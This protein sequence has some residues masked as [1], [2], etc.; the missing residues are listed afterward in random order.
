MDILEI[1]RSAQFIEGF[2]KQ[3]RSFAEVSNLPIS[4]LIFEERVNRAIVDSGFK[5]DWHPHGNSHKPGADILG[6]SLKTNKITGQF[7]GMTSYRTATFQTFEDKKNLIEQ[8]DKLVRAYLFLARIATKGFTQYNLYLI[9][10]EADSFLNLDT[11]AVSELNG[12]YSG[13]RPDGVKFEIRKST[14]GQLIFT[15]IPLDMIK[16]NL[17]KVFSLNHLEL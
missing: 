13:I 2:E 8:H 15:K 9:E 17:I 11:Y 1:I 14:S 3:V 16:K 4:G 6:L 10:K 5:T 7:A 12:N